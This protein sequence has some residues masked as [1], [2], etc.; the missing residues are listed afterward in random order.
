MWTTVVALGQ[1]LND[2]PSQGGGIETPAPLPQTLATPEKD[3]P[4][5]GS[6]F[7]LQQSF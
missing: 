6:F 3:L 7:R 2:E 5:G 4:L 1:I